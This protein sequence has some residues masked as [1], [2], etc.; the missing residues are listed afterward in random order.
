MQK[1]STILTHLTM[2]FMNTPQFPSTTTTRVKYKNLL[3]KKLNFYSKLIPTSQSLQN[4]GN[5]T[6]ALHQQAYNHKSPYL[7]FSSLPIYYLFWIKKTIIRN[8]FFR[9]MRYF[10]T[11]C[12]TQS[13]LSQIHSKQPPFFQNFHFYIIFGTFSCA[14]SVKK[15]IFQ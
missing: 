1:H 4:F 5:S 3:E 9:L 2:P 6:T 7:R 12:R 8:N 15:S 10:L 14:T 11:V 13:L